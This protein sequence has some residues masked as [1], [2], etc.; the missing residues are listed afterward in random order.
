[1]VQ[2]DDRPAKM[3]SLTRYKFNYRWASSEIKEWSERINGKNVFQNHLKHK[4][5]TITKIFGDV[6]VLTAWKPPLRVSWRDQMGC[7]PF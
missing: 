3:P 2:A 6:S 1:M 4:V 5:N 7:L